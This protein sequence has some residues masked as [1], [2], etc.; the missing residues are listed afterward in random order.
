VDISLQRRRLFV[1][2][3]ITAGALIVALVGVVASLGFHLAWGM[4]LFAA[5]I[6][7]GFASHGWLMLGVLRE[8]PASGSVP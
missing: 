2:L 7:T 1:T 8:K 4:W 6:L 3:A 5:A